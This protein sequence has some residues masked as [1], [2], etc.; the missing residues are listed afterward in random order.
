MDIITLPRWEEIDHGAGE[1]ANLLRRRVTHNSW[2]DTAAW[3]T[4][5]MRRKMVFRL[6][7]SSFFFR[8]KKP[9][10]LGD[11]RLRFAFIPH[12]TTITNPST[13]PPS[14][15]M[16]PDTAEPWPPSDCSG[17]P[18]AP[19]TTGVKSLLLFFIFLPPSSSLR[20]LTTSSITT[21]QLDGWWMSPCLT[22][23]LAK[24]I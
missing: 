17:L 20:P 14:C 2:E 12:P 5:G 8:C 24:R 13:A 4:S 23:R 1:P 18:Y 6:I 7:W 21:P 16:R 22:S 15:D 11:G 3:W 19:E 10:L 9:H